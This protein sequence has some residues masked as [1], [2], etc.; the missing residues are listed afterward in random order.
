MNDDLRKS[1]EQ[2]VRGMDDNSYQK[3]FNHQNKVNAIVTLEDTKNMNKLVQDAEKFSKAMTKAFDLFEGKD[4]EKLSTTFKKMQDYIK[5]LNNESNDAKKNA[6]I[7]NK[8]VEDVL[9]IDGSKRNKEVANAIKKLIDGN[10]E[11]IETANEYKRIMKSSS[12]TFGQNLMGNVKKVGDD[13]F[14]YFI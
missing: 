2:R 6:E 12:E 13:K 1:A 10:K 11:V 8:M 5:D 9:K 3:F 4:Y 14:E 7:I